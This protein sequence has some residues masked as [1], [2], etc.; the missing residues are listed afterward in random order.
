MCGPHY[1][2]YGAL[3][4]RDSLKNRTTAAERGTSAGKEN[5]ENIGILSIIVFFTE[6]DGR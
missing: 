6:S 1:E 4:S 5:R 3:M 2:S